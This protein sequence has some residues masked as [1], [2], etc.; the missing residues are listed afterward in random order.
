[1]LIVIQLASFIS[2][3][4]PLSFVLELWKSRKELLQVE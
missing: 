3:N 4:S 2:S 1:M